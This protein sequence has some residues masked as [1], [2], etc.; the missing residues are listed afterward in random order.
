MCFL[1][2]HISRCVSGGV[3]HLPVPLCAAVYPADTR[4][5]FTRSEGRDH[6]LR[7]SGHRSVKGFTGKS[8]SPDPVFL[9][10]SSGGSRI[11]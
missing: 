5:D 8:S 4:S 6:I 9:K 7:L 3:V 11:F 10:R 1:T 2:L